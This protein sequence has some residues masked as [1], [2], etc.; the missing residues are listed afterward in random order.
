MVFDEGNFVLVGS[1]GH[2]AGKHSSFYD[3]FRIENGKN[4]RTLGHDRSNSSQ[5]NLEK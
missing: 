3:L 1:E 5:K 4:S 2:L